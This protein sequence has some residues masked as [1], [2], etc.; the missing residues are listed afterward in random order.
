MNYV[1]D[2]RVNMLV[3][4]TK[5]GALNLYKGEYGNIDYIYIV[6]EAGELDYYGQK[7]NVEVNDIILRLYSRGTDSNKREIVIIPAEAAKGWVENMNWKR[8]ET[9]KRMEQLDEQVSCEPTEI[10]A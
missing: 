7:F 8:R 5:D 2:S 4:L 1:L 10:E 3:G 9:E 6:K